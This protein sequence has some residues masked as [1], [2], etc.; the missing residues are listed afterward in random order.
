MAEILSVIDTPIVCGCSLRRPNACADCL[1]SDT[2]TH[3]IYLDRATE[4]EVLADFAACK[5]AAIATANPAGV[6]SPNTFCPK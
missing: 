3:A 1:R 2:G 4:L 5:R 6:L